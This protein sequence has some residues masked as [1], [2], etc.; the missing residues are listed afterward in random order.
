[1]LVG[2]HGHGKSKNLR[3]NVDEDAPALDRAD[4]VLLR[5]T[6]CVDELALLDDW[7]LSRTVVDRLGARLDVSRSGARRP[8]RTRRDSEAREEFRRWVLARL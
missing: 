1:M 5:G 8:R 3:G 6:D 7:A 2:F 4:C